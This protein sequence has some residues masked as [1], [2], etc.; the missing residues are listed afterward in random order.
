MTWVISIYTSNLLFIQVDVCVRCSTLAWWYKKNHIYLV[1]RFKII[2]TWCRDIWSSMN[3]INVDINSYRWCN[4]SLPRFASDLYKNPVPF[5]KR[6]LFNIWGTILQT[7]K[8]CIIFAMLRVFSWSNPSN[9]TMTHGSTKPVI[10]M[11]TRAK[12]SKLECMAVSH[13]ISSFWVTVPNLQ[14]Q[15]YIFTF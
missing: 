11:N 3:K 15:L 12:G 10:E 13:D 5:Y 1:D 2:E 8:L 7:G 9:H 4:I 6:P 14:G